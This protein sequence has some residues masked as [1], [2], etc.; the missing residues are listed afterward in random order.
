MRRG[1]FWS[2][3]RARAV[4][5]LTGM[6]I[7]FRD[8]R[9]D[10]TR[11]RSRSLFPLLP[12]SQRSSFLTLGFTVPAGRAG[13]TTVRTK[14]RSAAG[15]IRERRSDLEHIHLFGATD[16]RSVTSANPSRPQGFP[17]FRALLGQSGSMLLA[18]LYLFFHDL[19]MSRKA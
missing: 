3:S 11:P 15:V 8:P 2:P 19:R 1:Q 7:V 9:M 12:R 16:R 4:T 14:R 6:P 10:Q 18:Q 13:A 17:V 5:L